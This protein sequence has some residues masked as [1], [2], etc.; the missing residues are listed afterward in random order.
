MNACSASFLAW[1]SFL[2]TCDGLPTAFSTSLH[3]KPPR[4][5]SNAAAF[6]IT[7]KRLAQAGF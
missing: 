2:I 4:S 6:L 1:R 7:F 3:T 5:P